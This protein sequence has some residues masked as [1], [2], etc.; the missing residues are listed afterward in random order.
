V[1][2]AREPGLLRTSASDLVGR[3]VALAEAFPAADVVS[4][5]QRQPGLLLL[6]VR[7]PAA[8]G[9]EP[10]RLP[11]ERPPPIDAGSKAPCAMLGA[12]AQHVP[13]RP[14]SQPRALR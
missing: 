3:L 6:E 11:P 4:M 1:Q 12:A 13:H 10:C 9:R 7:P 2:V 14:H 5:V 8:C